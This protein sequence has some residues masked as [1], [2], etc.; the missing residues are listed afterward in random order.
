MS[1]QGL[2]SLEPV[3]EKVVNSLSWL[4]KRHEQRVENRSFLLRPQNL[5][6]GRYHTQ[7]C[8]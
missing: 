2:G 3:D 6:A 7:V 1:C 4:G 5:V 8:V